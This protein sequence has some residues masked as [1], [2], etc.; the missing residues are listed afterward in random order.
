MTDTID[1]GLFWKHFLHLALPGP[2]PTSL[3]AAFLYHLLAPPQ[4]PIY[5]VWGPRPQP[6]VLF[7]SLHL[8]IS[9]SLM[10]LNVWD[11]LGGPVVK[12][13]FQCRE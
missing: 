10:T 3:T 1:Y 5:S 6:L 2:P 9:S 11:F 7:I 12:N 13:A 8:V 4:I